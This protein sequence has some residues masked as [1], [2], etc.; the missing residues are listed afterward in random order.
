VSAY[1]VEHEIMKHDAVEDVAVYAVPSELAED[2]IMAAVKV[3]EG[4]TFDPGEL[5]AF[6]SDKLA[7]FA[8]P[9]Y[10]RVVEA[11]PMTNSHRIIKGVL[12]NE[13]ITEETFDARQETFR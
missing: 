10:I 1:E 2:E 7:K 8:I 12:E 4:K 13:G 6:L 9:R 11:F 5:H 3:V